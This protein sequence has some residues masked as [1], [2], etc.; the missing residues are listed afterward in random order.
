MVRAQPDFTEDFLDLPLC[1]G[2]RRPCGVWRS[3]S[4][5]ASGRVYG[6]VLTHYEHQSSMKS[7]LILLDLLVR[8]GKCLG[9]SHGPR[10][11]AREVGERRMQGWHSPDSALEGKQHT[12]SARAAER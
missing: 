9:S 7:E 6:A 11:T 3:G 4:R 8:P 12:S 10:S 1:L 5:A 2:D